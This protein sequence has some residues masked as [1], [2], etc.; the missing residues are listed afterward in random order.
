MEP[1]GNDEGEAGAKY[2]SMPEI[3]LSVKNMERMPKAQLI[4]HIVHLQKFIQ[5]LK[6]ST[7]EQINQEDTKPAC[8]DN[9]E[10]NSI[11][12]GSQLSW[13]ILAKQTPFPDPTENSTKNNYMQI[14]SSPLRKKK[15]TPTLSPYLQKLTKRPATARG[16]TFHGHRTIKQVYYGLS[17]SG[18]E[19]V[20][21]NT[22][23]KPRKSQSVNKSMRRPMSARRA[24]S[25][26]PNNGSIRRDNAH[27]RLPHDHKKHQLDINGGTAFYPTLNEN[28]YK[29]IAEEKAKR[30]MNAKQC[31]SV[32]RKAKPEKK[33]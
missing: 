1:K 11:S 5:G 30:F 25:P 4:F 6:A 13:S 15:A 22:G 20:R 17:K 26:R 32:K 21:I 3:Y 23:I 16:R 2:K 8:P 19:S 12:S 24:A 10:L 9:A 18:D 14:V 27:V 28:I 31:V 29:M 33:T 7:T